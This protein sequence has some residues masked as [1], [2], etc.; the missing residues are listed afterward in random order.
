MNKYTGWDCTTSDG[1]ARR[2]LDASLTPEVFFKEYVQ[3]RRPVL[4]V[5]PK[6]SKKGTAAQEDSTT[7]FTATAF[8]ASF[9]KWTPAYLRSKCAD[10][11]VRVE[12]RSTTTPQNSG[13]GKF[14]QGVRTT[15]AFGEFV[16]RS[17]SGDTNLY[18]TTQVCLAANFCIL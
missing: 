14:G 2:T 18:L 3:P 11:P 10:A 12:Q 15:M 1:I 13:P 5:L 16:D 8:G 7:S 4:L 17:E 9:A 6:G